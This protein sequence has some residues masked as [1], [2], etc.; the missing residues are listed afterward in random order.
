M[1][2]GSLV[3]TLNVALEQYRLITAERELL[4]RTLKGSVKVLND[5]LSIVSPVAFS[6]S[7]RVCGMT[8]RLAN[9]LNVE[10][11]WKVELAA[12]LSQIGCVTIPGETLEK[13]YRDETLTK[14][15]DKMFLEHPNIGKNLLVNI[16]RLEG[17]AE[18]IAYQEKRFDG[19]DN[20]NDNKKGAEIPLIA[21]IL[22]VALDYDVMLAKGKTKLHSLAEMRIHHQW[23][24]PDVFAALEAEIISIKE[25]YVVREVMLKDIIPGMVLAEDVKTMEGVLLVQ[26][27]YEITDILKTRLLNIGRVNPIAEPIKIVKHM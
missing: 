12:M 2:N 5:I 27:G 21:R 25:G 11:I 9:R 22:K 10:G 17:V 20:P 18:A 15:E 26:N 14:E 16:P 23:Y 1:S 24:D 19:S 3:K 13:R 8:K 6:R 7:S 4:E